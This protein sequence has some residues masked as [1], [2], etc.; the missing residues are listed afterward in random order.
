MA[1]RGYRGKHPHDDMN[2][3]K[4]SNQNTGKAHPKLKKQ[5]DELKPKQ[6]YPFIR[7][8]E[9]FFPQGTVSITGH[10]NIG[11]DAEL[12]MSAYNGK[13]LMISGAA[14]DSTTLGF[15]S[16]GNATQAMEG[17]RDCVNANM[18]PYLSAS[19]FKADGTTACATTDCVV[20]ITQQEPGPDGN[21]SL[22]Y[23]GTWTGATTPGSFTGG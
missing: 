12:T 9:G 5:Y 2:V 19:A 6:K 4:H 18:W 17:V 21:T 3:S 23:T 11:N 1:K 20:T 8:H 22:T 10:A 7:D 13:T 14:D 15:K 16:D